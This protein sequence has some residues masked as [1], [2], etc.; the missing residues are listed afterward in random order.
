MKSI[1]AAFIY[2]LLIFSGH[3]SFCQV[4]TNP[5]SALQNILAQLEGEKLSLSQALEYG[6]ENSTSLRIA[7]GTF[8]AASGVLRREK[9]FFDP[10]FFFSFNYEDR[11]EP[12]ASFFS[13]ADVLNIQQTTSLAGLRLNLPTGTELELALNAIKLS[14]NSQFAFLNPQYNAF[15]NL[16]LRQS[17]LGGFTASG[18]KLLTQAELQFEAAKAQYDQAVLGIETEVEIMYWDLYAAERNYAVQKLITERA[19]AFLNETELREKAGLVG[20]NQVANAKTFL[21]EQELLFID[22]TEQLD[23]L[24]DRL[25]S[26][27]GTRPGAGLSR[28]IAIDDPPDEFPIKPVEELVE[29]ALNS[30]LDLKAM[31]KYVESAHTLLDAAV[32][33]ALPIVDLVGSYSASGLSGSPHEVIFG[34]DTL[35]TTRSG[36]F[37]N[38][39]NN[40]FRRDF[41]GWSLGVEITIPIGLRPGLGEEDR[42]EAEVLIVQQRYIE[43]SRLLE[44]QV[45]SAYRELIH[46]KDR[47]RAALD[48]VRAAQEQVRIGVIEF[49]NGR[50]TAFELVRLSEDFAIAQRRYSD[51]LVRTAKSAATLKQLTSGRYSAA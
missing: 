33:E 3:E 9:G 7:E 11:E 46:G 45:R 29:S 14:T 19:E 32:W 10:E 8:L 40:V 44:E 17:L 37:S 48:G 5:D 23:N 43:L 13:G 25:A 18:R 1:I 28:F 22:R 34:E 21:A 2:V 42:L 6:Q 51:A 39:L 41:S 16:S 50:L 38:S 31:Q 4:I 36:S 35:R 49:Q 15:G 12:T 24:S 26:L 20:P 30:N 27:I 47:L